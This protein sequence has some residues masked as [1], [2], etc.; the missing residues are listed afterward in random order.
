MILLSNTF[1]LIANET[2]A[3]LIHLKGG[4]ENIADMIF[5]IV[6]DKSSWNR[7]KALFE[8]LSESEQMYVL[9]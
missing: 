3:M 6:E 1:E 2:V 7:M 4:E 9:A 8:K 5:D